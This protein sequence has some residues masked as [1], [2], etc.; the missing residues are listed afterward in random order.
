[1]F[2]NV[3]QTLSG[4]SDYEFVCHEELMDKKGIILPHWL[5]CCI[6]PQGYL[7]DKEAIL[8]Y[9]LHQKR[10]IARKMKEFERQKN[11]VQV[12]G[13]WYKKLQCFLMPVV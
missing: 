1:M 5:C 9:I 12:S 7:Y 13:T 11:K 4:F 6:R 10:E 2:I 8:E 3:W